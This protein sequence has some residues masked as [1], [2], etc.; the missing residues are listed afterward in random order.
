MAATHENDLHAYVDNAMPASE[1]QRFAELL[2]ADTEAACRVE[3]YRRQN[4]ELHAAFDSVLAE[5]HALKLPAARGNAWNRRPWALA[6]SLAIGVGIGFIAADMLPG[7][8]AARESLV[9]QAVLAHVAYVPEVRHPVE[10]G[11]QEE[12]HLVAWLSKRLAV[13]LRA[14]RLDAAGYRLLGGR[15]L[16]AAGSIGDAPVALL[17]YENT[18]GKRISLL[19]RREPANKDTAFRFA[20]EGDTR[21]FY[22]IDGPYG[23]ALAGDIEREELLRLSR[24]VYQQLNP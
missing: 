19:F 3:A 22:W 4:D 21:V 13:P 1:R 10:V 8:R 7:Q 6:A 5:P 16:P 24:L 14:P 18:K 15:L 12:E 2:H 9:Q 11:A 23:C 20:Q 17:M